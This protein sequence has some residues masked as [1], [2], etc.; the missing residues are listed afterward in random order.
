MAILTT[1]GE[2]RSPTE[3]SILDIVRKSFD[4]LERVMLTYKMIHSSHKNYKT[5]II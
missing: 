4:G 2:T 5:W 3:Y 1:E